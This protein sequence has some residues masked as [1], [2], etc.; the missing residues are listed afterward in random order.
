MDG[1]FSITSLINVAEL[2]NVLHPDTYAGGVPPKERMFLIHVRSLGRELKRVMGSKIR[3]QAEGGEASL[4]VT[5]WANGYL[6]YQASALYNY[7]RIADSVGITPRPPG[8]TRCALE[9]GLSKCLGPTIWIE[10]DAP[11]FSWSQDHFQVVKVESEGDEPHSKLQNIA[12]EA[13]AKLKT[14]SGGEQGGETLDD[15]EWIAEGT[16]ATK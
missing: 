10:D 2:A 3:L 1:L 14:L 6:H 9:S 8:F 15:M 4:S 12:I 11:T 5:S 16:G 7:K 13:N